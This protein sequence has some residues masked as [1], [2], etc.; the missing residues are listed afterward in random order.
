MPT[1][2]CLSSSNPIIKF[3]SESNI[4]NYN[5]FKRIFDAEAKTPG[6]IIQFKGVRTEYIIIKYDDSVQFN[7]CGTLD[8]TVAYSATLEELM[9]ADQVDGIN[10]SRDWTKIERIYPEGYDGTFQIYFECNGIEHHG[11]LISDSEEQ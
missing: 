3:T 10:L 9:N 7:R 1:V 8:A 6:F 5:E 11:E 2:T 4:I